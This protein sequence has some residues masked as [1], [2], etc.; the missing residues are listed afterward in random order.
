MGFGEFG[1]LVVGLFSGLVVWWF[2]RLVVWSFSRL[3]FGEFGCLVVW[4]FGH[5]LTMLAMSRMGSPS[6]IRGGQGALIGGV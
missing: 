5:P 2:G 4:L 1:C 6:K 3:G